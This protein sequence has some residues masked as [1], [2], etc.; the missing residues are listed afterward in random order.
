MSNQQSD[1]AGRAGLIS[2]LDRAAQQISSQSVLFGEAVAERLGMHPSDLEALGILND[3]GPVPAG[4]LAA[5]TGLTSG[6]ITRMIDRLERA[7]YVRREPDPRDRR[8][9]IVRVAMERFQEAAL[10]FE[11]MQ[12]AAHD[13]Y[14]HYTDKELGLILD[15][16][17]KSYDMAVR[18]TAR[19]R[20]GALPAGETGPAAAVENA[21]PPSPRES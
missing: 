15:F 19:L 14:A 9:V 16:M 6:A 2:A 4:R 3:E 8:R 21:I 5:V 12:R 11:P 18:E 7:G 13:L 1:V 10:F 20:T 17:S